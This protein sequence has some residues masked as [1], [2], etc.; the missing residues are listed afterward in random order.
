MSVEKWTSTTLLAEEVGVKSQFLREN[1]LKLFR[2]GY[3][4]RL[5][6]PTAYRPTYTWHIDRCKAYFDKATK[7]AAKLESG[8]KVATHGRRVQLALIDDIEPYEMW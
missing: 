1:R 2:A 5:K 8:Q 6:N 4:Y 7:A 3:H